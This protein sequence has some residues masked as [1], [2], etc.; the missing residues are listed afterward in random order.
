MGQRVNSGM[1]SCMYTFSSKLVANLKN[2][3]IS[4]K[5]LGTLEKN[6]NIANTGLHLSKAMIS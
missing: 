2:Q 6:Q 3:D 4:H 1:F 5:N